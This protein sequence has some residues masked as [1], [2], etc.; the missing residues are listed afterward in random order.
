MLADRKDVDPK[1]IA[2]IGHSEG[3]SVAMIAGAKDKRIAAVGSLATPGVTGA[4][5]VLAQQ[6]HLL[7]RSTLSAEE[8]QAK[9]RS[10]RNAFIEAVDHWQGPGP[11]AAGRTARASTTPEYQS[12]LVTDPSK[13]DAQRAQ[14]AAH[15]PARAGHAGRAANADKLDVAGEAA[16]ERAAGRDVVKMPGVNHLLVPATTGEVEDVR[17]PDGP[18]T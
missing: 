10:R 12:I 14:A 3:G 6:K 13:L 16:Q 17:A 8:K 15:R 9:D 5:V 7:D 18:R 11:V 1:R 4:E 2:V